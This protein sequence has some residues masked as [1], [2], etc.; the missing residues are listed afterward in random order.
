MIESTIDTED[1]YAIL[2]PEEVAQYLNK[3]VSWV[4]K[5]WEILGGR[6]L[7]G[8]LFF[9][10]KEELYECI[11]NQKN[12]VEIRLHSQRNQADK[13]RI[14]NQNFGKKS[15]SKKKGGTGQPKE[16]NKDPNRH[17]LFGIAQQKT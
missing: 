9:P 12:G 17:G 7:G 4:Y 14:Q 5:H 6:K 10:R 3:S 11:F 2:T 8:S 1:K 16:G 15:R 13:S